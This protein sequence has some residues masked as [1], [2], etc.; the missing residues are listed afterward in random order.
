M[1][2]NPDNL[3]TRTGTIRGANLDS[4]HQWLKEHRSKLQPT[5]SKFAVG[6]KELWIRRY[7]DLRRNPTIK[8]GYRNDRIEALGERVLPGFHIGLVLL[9]APGTCIK[10][11]RDHGV[12]QPITVGVNLGR[13]VFCVANHNMNTHDTQVNRLELEDGD[14]IQFNNKIPHA[15][16]PSEQERWSIIFWHLKDKYLT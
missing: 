7:C 4:L 14:V 15:T 6:R 10:L 5:V 11:H 13:G 12:F 16:E 1:P 2:D 9:Y 3:V 8:E